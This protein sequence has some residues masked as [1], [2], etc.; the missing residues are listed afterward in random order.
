[1]RTDLHNHTTRCNHATGTVDAYIER[2]IEL[3]IDIY[4][5]SEHAPMDFDPNYRLK[6]EEMD[7]YVNDILKAKEIYNKDIKILLGYEV[8]YLPQHMDQR[9]L[10]ARVDYLIGSVHFINSWGFDNP[11]FIGEYKNRDIDTIWQEYFDA[12]EA[13]ADSGQFDI[14][15]HFD[16]IKVFKYMPTKDIRLLADK[17]LKMIKKS[18]MVLEI[19]TAG[20]RKPIKEI[21]PSKLLLEEAYTLEIPVT[22]GSDAHEVDQVGFAYDQ[23]VSLAKSVG[24]TK[25]VTFEQRDRELV[26]F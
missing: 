8:D 23:A 19:N 20:L 25:A 18:N 26:I 16:L 4:G 12:I 13:M 1:M 24:Y 3:G 21:Y 5:F 17:A 10:S 9:I 2:A 22:F 6:F 7:D 15:G 11:E 14:V